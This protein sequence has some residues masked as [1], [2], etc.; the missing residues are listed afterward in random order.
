MSNGQ[1]AMGNGRWC[2]ICILVKKEKP[3]RRGTFELLVMYFWV[4]LA[5]AS[6]LPILIDFEYSIS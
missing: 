3:E 1:W 4:G 5:I 2:A 6:R